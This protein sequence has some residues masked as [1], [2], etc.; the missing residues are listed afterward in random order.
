MNDTKNKL[1]DLIDWIYKNCGSID[2]LIYLLPIFVLLCAIYCIARALW[3]KRKFGDNFAIVR[4]KSL[5]NEF[6]RFLL[7]CWGVFIIC[8]LLTPTEFW[9]Y[10]W[11]CMVQGLEYNP[12]EDFFRAPRMPNPFPYLLSCIL[13]GHPEWFFRSA[14]ITDILL[15]IL[16]FVPLG[17]ALPFICKKAKLLKITLIGFSLSFV[18]EIVQIFLNGRSSNIDDLLCNTAGAALGYALYVLMKKVFPKFTAK[19]KLSANNVFRE[20]SNSDTQSDQP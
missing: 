11:R 10:F 5:L 9:N 8:G 13:N 2:I 18:I 3:H 19:C 15:N 17:L 4:K 12:F 16:L 14:Q 1:I 7:V 20:L 6:I